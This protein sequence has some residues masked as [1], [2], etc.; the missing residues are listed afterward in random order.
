MK[1]VGVYIYIQ[2]VEVL[3]RTMRLMCLIKFQVPVVYQ[4]KTTLDLI[5]SKLIIKVR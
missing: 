3:T 2:S 1:V 4:T 5:V